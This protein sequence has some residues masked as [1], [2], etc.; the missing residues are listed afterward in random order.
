MVCKIMLFAPL[1]QL[2]AVFVAEGSKSTRDL[3]RFHPDSLIL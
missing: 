2:C 1:L 3:L